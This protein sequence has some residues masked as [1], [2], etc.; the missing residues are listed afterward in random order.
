MTLKGENNYFLVS[1]AF[2]NSEFHSTQVNWYSPIVK[3]RDFNRTSLPPLTIFVYF[4]WLVRVNRLGFEYRRLRS[5]SQTLRLLNR[6][7]TF[8]LQSC[9]C[10]SKCVIKLTIFNLSS[11]IFPAPTT[12]GIYDLCTNE[13]GW[14]KNL[15]T[16][17]TAA[18][19]EDDVR[20]HAASDNL[21]YLLRLTP[22]PTNWETQYTRLVL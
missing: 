2:M 4:L 17:E 1:S 5:L 7:D 21:I 15:W 9:G 11:L 20:L 18:D 22:T 6:F 19:R 8:L 3:A 14:R 13:N 16:E 12:S 10:R